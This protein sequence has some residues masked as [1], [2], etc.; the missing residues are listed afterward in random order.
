MDRPA[1]EG[2]SVAPVAERAVEACNELVRIAPIGG[3]MFG[4]MLL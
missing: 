2:L 1:W 3:D 4:L